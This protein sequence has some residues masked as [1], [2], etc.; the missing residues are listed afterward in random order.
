MISRKINWLVIIISLKGFPNQKV[1]VLHQERERP[2]SQS[3]FRLSI[4]TMLHYYQDNKNI[5]KQTS[6]S[7]KAACNKFISTGTSPN[8]S[9]CSSIWDNETSTLSR[10]SNH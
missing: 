3:Q 2:K 4:Y 7:S 10:F 1:S 9:I 8:C 5:D 6:C